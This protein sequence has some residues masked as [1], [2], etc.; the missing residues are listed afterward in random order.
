[1]AK[2]FKLPDLGEGIHEG[3]VLDVKVE[4]GQQVNEDDIIL[5]VETDKAAVEIPSPYGDVVTDVKVAS[6]DMVHVG[7]VMMIFGG[8]ADNAPKEK[9]AKDEAEKAEAQE[10]KE[11]KAPAGGAEG[12]SRGEPTG[13]PHRG[14][15]PV[16]AAPST[17]RLARELSV[18]LHE[19]TPSGPGGRVTKEDVRAYA[20]G[21]QTAE[22]E[23]E[24]EAERKAE[25]KEREEHGVSPQK[26]HVPPLPDYDKV[27]PVERM[28]LRS[29]RRATA[30][31][32]ALSWSQI[33]HVSTQDMA[34]ITELEKLREAYKD[35]IK[36]RDGA[37]TLTIFVV[38]A[39]IN[40]LKDFPKFNATL[41][42]ENEEII[43]KK[44]YNVGIAVDTERGLV[45][46]ALRDADQKS[47]VEL[48]QEL[49]EL[50]TRTREGKASL[51]D[52][53]GSTMTITNVGAIGG[54]NFTPI[55]NFPE[56]AI[57]GLAQARVQPVAK[58]VEFAEGEE[59]EQWEDQYE[60]V[61]RLMLPIILTFDHRVN[62]GAEAQR[63][64]N[65]IIEQLENPE[66]LLLGL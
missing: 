26:V 27:G 57:L 50:V 53:Q 44:Y 10:E 30:R 3:E 16:P 42:M 61:P 58:T 9:K 34:D 25:R 19:V 60:F 49:K 12:E 39:L 2:E 66:R 37:L 8:T 4:P 33:P 7:E 31:Q 56:V 62:D 54:T 64:L 17:R 36:G 40:A 32:M 6:G 51:E 46:P 23:A 20:E 24:R 47:I 48:S 38:K 63:F 11:R 28:P 52:M 65:R 22:E 5:E 1:M 55:I 59:P 35:E 15:R 21:E 45:V 18:D 41:D 14:D 29:V 43:L 13:R